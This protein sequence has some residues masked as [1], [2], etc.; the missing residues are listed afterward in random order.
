MLGRSFTHT[1]STSN[2]AAPIQP[3]LSSISILLLCAW[4]P[5]ENPRATNYMLNH[6]FAWSRR[7]RQITAAKTLIAAGTPTNNGAAIKSGPPIVP[8]NINIPIRMASAA[9]SSIDVEQK[10][11]WT[12]H[13]S[14]PNK[15]ITPSIPHAIK[16]RPVNRKK[17]GASEGSMLRAETAKPSSTN[18]TLVGAK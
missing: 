7:R 6:V 8:S 14:L 1:I 16:C 12:G 10:R 2:R 15:Q 5:V 4:G 9:F 18:T 11:W 13:R 17:T 3:A